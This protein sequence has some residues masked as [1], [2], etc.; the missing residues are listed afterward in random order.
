MA[1]FEEI[2]RYRAK[3]VQ[4]INLGWKGYVPG[5]KNRA[6]RQTNKQIE[7]R[8]GALAQRM[9][10]QKLPG[11]PTERQT[12]TE[13]QEVEYS[14]QLAFEREQEVEVAGAV[15]KEGKTFGRPSFIKYFLLFFVLAAP[16][17]VIDAIELTGFLAV[18]AWF[19]SFF[20][21]VTSILIMWFTDQE[22]KRAQGFMKKVA[23][24]QKTAA[25]TVRTTLMVAKFFRNTKLAGL[26][27]KNPMFKIVAGAVA[28]MIPFLSIFPWSSISVILAYLDERKTYKNA[29][30]TGEEVASAMTTETA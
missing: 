23:E 1:E 10:Q 26:V 25:R 18:I 11:R 22:Q 28:E 4:K 3:E 24:Y 13:E 2:K 12:E 27:A 17:D 6:I 7:E 16:N 15:E 14:N 21:S 19:V 30:E 8:F 5:Y 20:L 9:E 29:R